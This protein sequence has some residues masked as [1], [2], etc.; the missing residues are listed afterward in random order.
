MAA[1]VVSVLACYWL[2]ETMVQLAGLQCMGRV[3]VAVLLAMEWQ[4]VVVCLMQVLA[5][6]VVHTAVLVLLVGGTPD[7]DA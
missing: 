3:S 4:E 5:E 2:L 7:M 1:L 6:Q